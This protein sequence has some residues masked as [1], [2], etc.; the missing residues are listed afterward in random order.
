M[1]TIC[2]TTLLLFLCIT[3]SADEIASSPQIIAMFAEIL[4]NGSYGLSDYESAAFV[5]RNGDGSFGC[6]AWPETQRF[7]ETRYP[8]E[9]PRGVVAIVHTH[10]LRMPLPSLNDRWCAK[11]FNIPIYAISRL[12]IY[13]A[14][15]DGTAIRIAQ[16][17]QWWTYPAVSTR[18]LCPYPPAKR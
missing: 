13:K 15:V 6:M 16:N 7:R 10:P 11:H 12:S 8:G 18:R 3:A 14:D 17:I 5:L 2:C 4:R 9:R 1:R